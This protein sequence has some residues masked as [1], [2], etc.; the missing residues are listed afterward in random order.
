MFLAAGESQR[1]ASSEF[2]GQRK[3]MRPFFCVCVCLSV[4]TV[5]PSSADGTFIFI[6]QMVHNSE[7]SFVL[8]EVFIC[9]H[10]NPKFN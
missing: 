2:P 10:L 8:W 9:I 1:T 4:Q 3:T 5:G 6:S 7:G